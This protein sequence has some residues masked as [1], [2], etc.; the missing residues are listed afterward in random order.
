MKVQTRCPGSSP[1]LGSDLDGKRGK[2][3]CWAGKGRQSSQVEGP[4]VDQQTSHGAR[5]SP[6]GARRMGWSIHSSWAPVCWA[7]LARPPPRQARQPAAQGRSSSTHCTTTSNPLPS[8]H[9]QARVPAPRRELP[10]A[11]KDPAA[12]GAAAE[13]GGGRQRQWQLPGVPAAGQQP[14][15]QGRCGV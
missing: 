2:R 8:R 11:Q 5:R 9:Q 12:P 15:W 3:N 6:C 14:G 10:R 13:A 1:V 4:R 7:R